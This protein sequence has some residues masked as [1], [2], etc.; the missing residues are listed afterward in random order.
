M[1]RKVLF[2]DD[3][4][5][6]LDLIGIKLEK[7]NYEKI[8]KTS[9]K[10]ALAYLDENEVDVVVTDIF[11]PDTGGLDLLDILKEKY[12]T[13]VR[14][15]LSGFSQVNVVLTAINKG[16]IYRFITKPWK[17]DDEGKKIIRDALEYAEFL[18]AADSAISLEVF[19]DVMK[20]VGRKYEIRDIYD[21][22][23]EGKVFYIGGGKKI[24]L[25]DE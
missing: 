21:D 15:V 24:V 13:T 23:V 17:V 6:I 8:F 14:I 11:M 25:E 12:P 18:K 9:V 10:E 2:V 3:Q 5:E 4:E 1:S 20:E 16:D 7:E 19:S 22:E